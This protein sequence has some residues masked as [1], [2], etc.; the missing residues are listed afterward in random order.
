M[1]E[2]ARH[3]RQQVEARYKRVKS[4]ATSVLDGD[5]GMSGRIAGN[6]KSW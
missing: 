6:K 4:G 1:D 5:A 2:K 3:R